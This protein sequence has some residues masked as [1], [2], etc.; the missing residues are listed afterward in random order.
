MSNDDGKS[1]AYWAG[2]RADHYKDFRDR[3]KVGKPLKLVPTSKAPDHTTEYLEKSG[4]VPRG[5]HDLTDGEKKIIQ[6]QIDALISV[7]NGE[8]IKVEE[9][10]LEK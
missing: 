7:R 9:G 2:K 8:T 6:N 5:W 3:V 1:F 10:Y 4:Y